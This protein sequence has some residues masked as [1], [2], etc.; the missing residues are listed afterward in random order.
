MISMT[1]ED[2]LS[3]NDISV[4]DFAS[5]IGVK[6]ARSVYRYINRERIPEKEIMARIVEATKG[7]VTPNSFYQ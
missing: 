6:G 2:W 7:N 3:Q 4:P 1:L 5:M